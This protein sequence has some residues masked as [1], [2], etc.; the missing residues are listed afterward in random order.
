MA[1]DPDFRVEPPVL[2]DYTNA[3][4]NLEVDEFHAASNTQANR[5]SRQA[6][7]RGPAPGR[8]NHNG[9]TAPVRAGRRPLHLDRRRRGRGDGL[10]NARAPERPAGQAPADQPPQA[11]GRSRTR[12]PGT[13]RTSASR[14]ATRST[15][16]G[17]AIPC[18]F[19]FDSA[20]GNLAIG[21]V[22]QGAWE[23]V[24][25]ET[26]SRC[27]G[28]VLRLAHFEG[29]P[30]SYRLRAAPDP[31][32]NHRPP[33]LPITCKRPTA[34]TAPARSSAASSSTTLSSSLLNGRYVYSDNCNGDIRSLVPT[35]PR[36][37]TTMRHGPHVSQPE[38]R[39]AS[40][41]RATLRRL[42]DV[43]YRIVTLRAAGGPPSLYRYSSSAPLRR[44]DGRVE[45]HG[46]GA[47]H[48][49]PQQPSRHPATEHRPTARQS[50]SIARPTGP[51]SARFRWIRPSGSPRSS[52]RV[53]AAQ[54]E[55]EAI[56][57]A[58]RR[59]WLER[60]RDWLIANESPC[61]GRDA[62]GDRQGPRRGR[63]GGAVHLR[64]DQLLLRERGR[65]PRRGVPHPPH[66]AA[67][68]EAAS[69][70]LPPLRRGGHH[71]PLELPR[72][73]RLR[74]RDPGAARRQR[75]GDQAVGVHAAVGHGDRPRVEGGDRRPGRARRR[76]R[77]RRD[78]RARWSTRS[79]TSSSRARTAPA[80]S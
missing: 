32:P 31:N 36:A 42:W 10:D 73:P 46:H 65:V 43:T 18:R 78:G 60:L 7:D 27:E 29:R 14:A 22:G 69:D 4:G 38:R 20:N 2:R 21:D 15:P 19:S 41:A 23:E 64:D 68:G 13:T 34:A 17:C 74:R 57:L 61:R 37:G 11:C 48:R 54:P 3:D 67:E 52:T 56:G 79:T 1:F 72:D 59:R 49:D 5:S 6:G 75:R 58:G 28:L 24:D 12:S 44:P 76:Q 33:I 70:R 51:S 26:A 80:R 25:Y 30:G 77:R 9:R 62:G 16:T 35:P 40:A 50:T 39:S 63:A 47:R 53:R 45:S 8:V 66:P 55:W 71:Q